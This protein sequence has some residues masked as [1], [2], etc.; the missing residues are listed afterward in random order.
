MSTLIQVA[1]AVNTSNTDLYTAYTGTG[2]SQLLSLDFQNTNSGQDVIIDVWYAPNG[3]GTL[4][5]LLKQQT[6]PAYSHLQWTGLV[7]L[8]TSGDKIRA[9]GNYTGVDCLGAVRE[10]A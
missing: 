8:P 6:I 2:P 5:Y 4:V 9:I 10:T 7:V 1:I 3:G